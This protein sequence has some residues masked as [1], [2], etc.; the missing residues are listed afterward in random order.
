[1]ARA[2]AGE[3]ASRARIALKRLIKTLLAPLGLP[4]ALAR[5]RPALRVLLYHRV[6]AYPFADLGPVSRE[7]TVRP[8]DFAWQLRH[9]KARG[10]RPVSA[11]RF[12][13]MALGAA[14]PEPGA[15]LITFDDGYEDN[16][17]FAA[18]LLDAEG[19]PAVVFA[20]ADFLGRSTGAVWPHG[21]AAP[22]GRFLRAS[23]LA[24]LA[25]H[26]VAV[27]SHTLSHPLLTRLADADLAAELAGSRAALETAVGAPVRLFAYPEG[28]VDDR[29]EAATRAAGYAL[30]FTTVT[31]AVCAGANPLRL[32]RTEVS[33]SDSRFIFALKM[34][35]A[36]DWT[37]IK[38]SAPARR[39]IAAL[40]RFA[41]RRMGAA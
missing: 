38:D 19:A 30:A 10:L 3:R 1:M 32:R 34:R 29:V 35:G 36:L 40:N 17:L 11:E 22:Y 4:F 2:M 13:A 33:A 15:V 23:Q 39:A 12:A 20:A 24:D 6:N 26:G 14:P 25:R 27:G 37:R 21:D 28:D 8:D 41:L 9:L 16:L 7:L 31:G 18:P 5:R